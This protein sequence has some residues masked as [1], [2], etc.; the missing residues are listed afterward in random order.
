MKLLTFVLNSKQ[1]SAPR[2]GALLAD[3]STLVDLRQAHKLSS[4]QD[5]L[6]FTDMLSFL[7]GGSAAREEAHQA[8]SFAE[9]HKPSDAMYLLREVSLLS[10][11]PKPRSIRD[12]MAFER[13][14]IQSMRRV[15][16]KHSPLLAAADEWLEKR[17]GRGFIRPPRVWYERPVYY[18]GNPLSVVGHEAEILWPSYTRQL[19]YELE[20][21]VFIGKKGCN[22]PQERVRDHIAGYTIFNDFSARDTQLREMSAR[23]GPAKGKDF[24]TG[25]ALGPFLVT[26]DE[27]PDP[28]AL[29][30]TARV[31]GNVWSQGI[32]RMTHSFEE[33]IAFISR[34]ETLYP[35]EFIGSGAVGGG[36]GL[37]TGRWLKGGDVIELEVEKL[38]LLR[39][40]I[41]P[42]KKDVKSA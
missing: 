15:V 34:D 18:K 37:E 20:F 21:G 3:G 10:P 1:G 36:C 42:P 16:K 28:Y 14:V 4:E 32:S 35:G 29:A 7:D 8:V 39:N 26:P 24:D 12:C 27:I 41:S 30:M 38:G 11:V 25:N 2:I 9:K 6:H 5:P 13:H 19:D 17:L 23:L 31:N 40:H 22:I 33:I